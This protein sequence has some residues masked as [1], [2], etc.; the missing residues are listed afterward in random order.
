MRTTIALIGS[1]ALAMTAFV[2]TAGYSQVQ[3]KTAAPTQGPR[4]KVAAPAASKPAAP[5]PLSA[6]S[7]EEKAIVADVEGFAKAYNAANVQALADFFHDDSSVIEPGGT[8]TRGKGPII[9]MYTA[10]FQ[11][12]PGL[13]LESTVE[14]IKFL[15]P[16]VAKVSGQSRLST[17]DGNAAEFTR[18][19]TLLVR[20]DGKWRIAEIRE[21]A[22]AAEDIS[23]HDRLQELEWMVG[24]WVDESEDNK[25]TAS[26]RWANG[27]SYLIRDYSIHIQGAMTASGT[28][29]IGWDPQSGQIKSWLFDSTGG[30]G[31]AFWTRT[32]DK[33]WVVK[34]QG[35]LRDGRATSATQI[36][37]ILNKDSVKTSSIDRIIGG[38]V[39]PD[40]TDIVMVRK[41]PQPSVKA[42]A[43]KP[44]GGDPT[45]K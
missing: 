3:T 31:E 12:T 19:S 35:V 42:P 6:S 44:S 21:D 5:V 36:H 2:V 38:V 23:A 14:E 11:D 45:P 25:V 7:P 9:E 30:H 28:M 22:A 13:K 34:A 33:E 26:V 37:T 24:E 41:P 10:A 20:R 18:F 27:Q 29:F 4:P 32:G 8:E 39:E 40:I 15:T 16:D 1:I 43:P 17:A